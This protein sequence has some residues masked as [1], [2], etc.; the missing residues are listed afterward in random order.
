MSNQD[1]IKFDQN[2]IQRVGN[3]MSITDKLL[4]SKQ[5]KIK[6]FIANDHSIF[7]E[8]LKK[9]LV[10][11]TDIVIVGQGG[12]FVEVFT[13]FKDLLPDILLTDDQMPQTHILEDIAHIKKLY[14]NLKIIMWSVMGATDFL[15]KDYINYVNGYITSFSDID[16]YVEVFKKVYAGGNYFIKHEFLNR[17][18]LKKYISHDREEFVSIVE[19]IVSKS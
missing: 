2:L 3:A 4:A 19:D 11:F 17:E 10:N 15:I 7:I 16:D 18:L 14:P 13:K 1:I 6:V 5:D 9:G 8:S 12:S